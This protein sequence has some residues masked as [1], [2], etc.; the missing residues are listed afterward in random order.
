MVHTS[1]SISEIFND[2]SRLTKIDGFSVTTCLV[3]SNGMPFSYWSSD[4]WHNEDDV[5]YEDPA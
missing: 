1:K 2:I 4:G 3:S 5:V